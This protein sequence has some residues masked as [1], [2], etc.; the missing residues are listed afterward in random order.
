MERKLLNYG[1]IVF[2]L[3]L[4]FFIALIYYNDYAI[5]FCLPLAP[6]IYFLSILL[7]YC[8]RPSAF[9]SLVVLAFFM[10]F[11]IRMMAVPLVYVIS[12]YISS[13]ET[14]AGIKYISEAVG[15]ICFEMISVTLYF[16]SSNTL[17][18]VSSKPFTTELES[19]S[20]N[21]SFVNMAVFGLV[22][23]GIAC[24]LYDRSVLTM[25]STV[26][27][28]FS[29]SAQERLE[30]RRAFLSVKES[31]SLLFNLF[32]QIVF[33]LQ[34]LLPAGLIAYTVNRRREIKQSRG[35]LIGLAVATAA[36]IFVTESN[37]DSVC[38]M[39]ACLLVLYSAYKNIMKMFLPFIATAV[40]VFIG[41]FLLSKT[42]VDYRGGID[43]SE[44]SRVLCAYFSTYP[45]V[46]CGFAVEY[47]NKIATLWGDIVSGVPYMMVFFRGYPKSL[48]LFNSAAHRFSGLNNQI[49]PLISTGYHFLGIFAPAFTI[50][51]YRIAIVLELK[52]R[53]TN[54]AFNRVLYSLMIIN[55]SVGPCI[56]GFSSTIKRLC[57]Y[58]P[59]LILARINQEEK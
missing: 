23:I 37:I 32:G 38:I 8:V 13:I 4:S 16:I 33:Y 11:F 43:F 48:T 29:S 5:S 10:M 7:V 44:L 57:Y 45:N 40:V 42:G 25:V 35:F 49:M 6:C 2:F 50:L 21:S 39:L 31:S 53:S 18:K 36:V 46:S 22:G 28:R 9:R 30:R 1:L 47:D 34:I 59:L 19:R 15:L 24:V 3:W 27:F 14:D 56:F 52:F 20:R 41:L 54:K 12:G 17:T 55:L 58:I 26:F 51:V